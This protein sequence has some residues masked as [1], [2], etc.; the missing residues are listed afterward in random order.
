MSWLFC[1]KGKRRLLEN[2]AQICRLGRHI[3]GYTSCPYFW[4]DDYASEMA[5]VCAISFAERFYLFLYFLYCVILWIVQWLW[6]LMEY[7]Y[8]LDRADECDDPYMQLVY[9]SEYSF[10]LNFHLVS[11]KY[12]LMMDRVYA[13]DCSIMGYICLLCLSTNLEAF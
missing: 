6:Q 1:F 12:C 11:A 10:T 2:D 8:L 3:N 7:S 13:S 5:E 9:A 4:A